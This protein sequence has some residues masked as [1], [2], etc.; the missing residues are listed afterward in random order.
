M[1]YSLSPTKILWSDL[2]ICAAQRISLSLADKNEMIQTFWVGLLT[3]GY[4]G[5]LLEWVRV[6]KLFLTKNVD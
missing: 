3:S 2:Q 1:V 6:S 4:N 5:S